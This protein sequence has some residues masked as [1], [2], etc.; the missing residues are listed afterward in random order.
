[1]KHLIVAFLFV[2]LTATPVSAHTGSEQT[3]W[4]ESWVEAVFDA[5]GLTPDLL[6]SWLDFQHRHPETVVSATNRSTNRPTSTTSKPAVVTPPG[7]AVERWRPLVE[8]YFQ[9]ADVPW[10][11]AVIRCES[12]GNPL[13]DNPHSTASGLFQH[14]G[15]FW[16]ERS[17]AAGWAGASIWDPE[18]NVAVAAWLLYSGGGAGH[19]NASRGCWG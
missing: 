15:S 13:A 5:G 1:M 4:E 11:L 10:A 7:P 14:L 8:T 12:G 9:P 6:D 17:A 3:G 18:P 16:A 19:W 2:A